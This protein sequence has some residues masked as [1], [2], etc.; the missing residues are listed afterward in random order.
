MNGTLPNPQPSPYRL[1]GSDTHDAPFVFSSPHSGRW[2][3]AAFRRAS[4]L[5]A[6]TLRRSEDCYV[7]DL[8]ATAA[9]AGA[10][11]IAAVY[12]RAYIDLNRAAE[13]LDPLLFDGPLPA[14]AQ[15]DGDRVS[16]GLGVIPRVVATGV[17]IYRQRL[18]I[19]EAHRRIDHIHRPYHTRLTD[20]LDGARRR[21]G[22]A[23]LID[24]HS[25]P[26]FGLRAPR[27][28][29]RARQRRHHEPLVADI[30]LGDRHGRSCHPALMDRAQTILSD[31][32]Y[33]VTRNDPYAG[34]F[35]TSHYGRPHR[36]LHALQIEIKRS[37]YMDEQTLA[38]TPGFD[39]LRR[40]LGDLVTGLLTLDLLDQ[41][42]QAAE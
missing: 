13:E 25:M 34:G 18:P 36:G 40:H 29:P 24:C 30:V 27:G 17:P 39:R 9:D 12:P 7:D 32:G 37:L 14:H 38:R 33:R 28:T 35:C 3:P 10:A 26:S 42:R 31:L 5:D 16:V 6:R 23:V 11:L 19:A 1:T 2:Y 22:W 20:L 15:A 41:G 8:F 21:H 4:R